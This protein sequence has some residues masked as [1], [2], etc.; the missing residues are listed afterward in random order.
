MGNTLNNL[1][2]TQ[3]A[4][5]F[6]EKAIKL[7]PDYAEAYNNLGNILSQFNNDKGAMDV[8]NKSMIVNSKSFGPRVGLCNILQNLGKYEEAIDVLVINLKG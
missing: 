3:E 5:I 7:K 4:I 1:G 6:Y 8:F 2:K